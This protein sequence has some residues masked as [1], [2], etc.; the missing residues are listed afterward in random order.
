MTSH[1][2]SAAPL[3]VTVLPPKQT[4][5]MSEIYLRPPANYMEPVTLLRVLRTRLTA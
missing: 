3:N 2:G 1:C 5:E 4:E